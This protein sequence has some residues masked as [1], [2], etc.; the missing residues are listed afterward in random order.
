MRVQ[1]EMRRLTDVEQVVVVGCGDRVGDEAADLVV[2]PLAEAGGGGEEVLIGLDPAP[3][4]V[5]G[6]IVGSAQ[7]VFTVPPPEG[8]TTTK[9]Q[10]SST[11][12]DRVTCWFARPRGSCR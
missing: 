4:E 11:G 2:G 7:V 8:C 6:Q 1:Y 10:D 9:Q 3:V 5:A 12:S